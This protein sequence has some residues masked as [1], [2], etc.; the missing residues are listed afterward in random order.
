MIAVV[1]EAH[2]VATIITHPP[3]VTALTALAWGGAYVTRTVWFN[4]KSSANVP[5]VSFQN[6][7][8]I[9]E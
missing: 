7:F 4:F 1:S 3:Q 9:P 6:I 8:F 5:F 2:A